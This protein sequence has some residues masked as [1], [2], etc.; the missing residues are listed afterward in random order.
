MVVGVIWGYFRDKADEHNY[1]IIR[2]D[3]RKLYVNVDLKP[4]M[5]VKK[6]KKKS[7]IS[8]MSYP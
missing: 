8:L 5:I 6:Q 1:E 2:S 3:K 4:R 7:E